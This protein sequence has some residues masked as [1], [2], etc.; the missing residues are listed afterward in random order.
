MMASI[1][2][3]SWNITWAC[4]ILR[5]LGDER[6]IAAAVSDLAKVP[7]STELAETMEAER[8]RIQDIIGEMFRVCKPEGATV[9]TKQDALKAAQD[10]AKP[11]LNNLKEAVRRIKAAG[12]TPSKAG[13]HDTDSTAEA[14]EK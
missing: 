11:I 12:I 3:P 8:P 6:K 14:S 7:L 4:L 5:L 10:K 9:E 13:A 2:V 1:R